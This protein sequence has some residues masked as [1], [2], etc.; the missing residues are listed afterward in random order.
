[1]IGPYRSD[2]KD[3][4]DGD[5]QRPDTEIG[6][7]LEVRIRVFRKPVRTSGSRY[8]AEVGHD[9]ILSRARSAIPILKARFDPGTKVERFVATLRCTK[10]GETG[11]GGM[12]YSTLFQYLSLRW[13]FLDLPES[14]QYGPRGFKV[15]AGRDRC[16]PRVSRA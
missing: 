1:L 7:P 12:Q 5:R 3:Y 14:S 13:R 16:K 11:N 15:R 2:G 4:R 10:G 6:K 8:Q 9:Q